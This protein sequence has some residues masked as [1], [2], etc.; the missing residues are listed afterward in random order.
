ML[1]APAAAVTGSD[2]EHVPRRIPDRGRSHGRGR[3]RPRAAARV[4]HA[5]A[6]VPRRA[7]WAAAAR[8]MPTTAAADGFG[9]ANAYSLMVFVLL[10]VPCAAALSAIAAEAGRARALKCAVTQ[11]GAAYAAACVTYQILSRLL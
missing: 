5:C 4:L 2:P 8:P 1:G 10:Y 9:A 11:L 6:A 3:H 7:R